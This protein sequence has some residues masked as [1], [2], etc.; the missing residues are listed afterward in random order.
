M[1]EVSC[2]QNYLF[3]LYWQLVT[4]DMG[5]VLSFLYMDMKLVR[6]YSQKSEC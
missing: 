3:S 1:T 6:T 2:N 5:L 4:T